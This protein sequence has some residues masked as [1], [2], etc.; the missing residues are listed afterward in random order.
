MRLVNWST[1]SL[2]F[3]LR[4][5]SSASFS[6]AP[7]SSSASVFRGLWPILLLLRWKKDAYSLA[8]TTLCY[9]TLVSVLTSVVIIALKAVFQCW[10]IWRSS[11][12]R[13][14]TCCMVLEATCTYT[15]LFRQ[16]LLRVSTRRTPSS[17]ESW[18]CWPIT[19]KNSK[20][21]ILKLLAW[22]YDIYTCLSRGSQRILIGMFLN[23]LN[24][25]VK[26]FK[27]SRRTSI[28][29]RNSTNRKVRVLYMIG[30]Y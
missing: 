18:G 30:A 6:L 26:N 19:A 24:I 5:S 28:S 21:K 10:I 9:S 16:I 11:G 29:H 1:I 12:K 27:I 13:S 20:S 22:T 8:D 23:L 15:T 2:S 3:I 25:E 14:I 17:P 4:L 7:P